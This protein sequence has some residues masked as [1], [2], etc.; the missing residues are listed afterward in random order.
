MYITMW[1]IV[2]YIG[3]GDFNNFVVWDEKLATANV[4]I[5]TLC[6]EKNFK[7][8]NRTVRSLAENYEERDINILLFHF[9]KVPHSNKEL[10]Y[11]GKW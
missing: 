2:A 8:I 1:K 9:L 11:S 3:N 6:N 10:E 5:K 4:I 7:S